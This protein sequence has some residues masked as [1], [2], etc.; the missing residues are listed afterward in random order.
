M[1]TETTT[2]HKGETRAAS[3][4]AGGSAMSTTAEIVGLP[5]GTR[6][7]ALHAHTY[8]SS[9]TVVKFALV[10]YL[11]IL[12]TADALATAPTDYS[13]EA[14]DGSAST[15]VTLDSLNTAAEN[16][17]LYVGSYVPFRG[18]DIDVTAA[19]GTSSVLTVKYWNGSAWTDISDTDGTIS[20]GKTLAQ[21]GQVTWTVPTA[22][23]AGSLVE[24]GDAASAVGVHVGTKDIYWT[25]WEV[26]T[27]IDSEVE[28]GH[29]LAMARSTA[30]A[31]LTTGQ[32]W[33]S[34]ISMGPGGIGGVEGLTDTGSAKLVVNC[35]T[36]GRATFV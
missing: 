20:S 31:E 15:V 24:L 22:W 16:D 33:E 27:Q 19:N 36:L 17:F 9:A 21:D 29:M 2:V 18:V 32:D 6:H 28:L 25:R 8:A 12:K 1:A 7:V 13:S 26:G 11:L 3:T 30:Y 10:P 35:S 5:E 23:T 14:Q 34:L 4:A